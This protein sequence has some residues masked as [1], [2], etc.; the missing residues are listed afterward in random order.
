MGV[1]VKEKMTVSTCMNCGHKFTYKEKFQSLNRKY[2]RMNCGVCG[3]R[4]KVPRVYRIILA[5][6]LIGPLFLIRS[7]SRYDWGWDISWST[8]LLCYVAVGILFFLIPTF[9]PLQLN[10]KKAQTKEDSKI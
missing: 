7:N 6:L 10:P 3:T 9:A 5:V 1:H 8:I 2:W 4:Y